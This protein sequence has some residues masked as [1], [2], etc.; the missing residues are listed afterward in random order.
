[1]RNIVRLIGA[2]AALVLWLVPTV[3]LAQSPPRVITANVTDHA[4]QDTGTV[5][6][7]GFVNNDPRDPRML[8]AP[9]TSGLPA[10]SH[11]LHR[12]APS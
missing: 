1:M 7:W 4:A 5:N 9:R 3:L 10:P 11:A 6:A 12:R 2:F 8:F